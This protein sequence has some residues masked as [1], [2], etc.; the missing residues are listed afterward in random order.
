MKKKCC[1]TIFFAYIYYIRLGEQL[2]SQAFCVLKM[3]AGHPGENNVPKASFLVLTLT[4][5][6][7]EQSSHPY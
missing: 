2:F 4:L 1:K 6:C 5:I 3:K 7:Y